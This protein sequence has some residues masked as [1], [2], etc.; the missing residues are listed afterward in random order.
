MNENLHGLPEIPVTDDPEL[1][2]VLLRAFE[3]DTRMQTVQ[4]LQKRG[5]KDDNL[6]RLVANCEAEVNDIT[7]NIASKPE[8][9]KALVKA[10]IDKAPN[11]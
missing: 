10:T 4:L 6:L 5:V 8:W 3:L 9:V 11:L 1:N 7:Q 2:K